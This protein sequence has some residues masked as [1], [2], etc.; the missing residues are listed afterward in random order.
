L[1]FST[2]RCMFSRVKMAQHGGCADDGTK[3][4]IQWQGQ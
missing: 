1:D 4:K 3:T 2:I